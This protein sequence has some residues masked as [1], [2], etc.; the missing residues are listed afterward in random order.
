VAFQS[1]SIGS[2]DS[3]LM[4]N[5]DSTTAPSDPT[6]LVATGGSPRWF[7][8]IAAT[9][10]TMELDTMGSDLPTTFLGVYIPHGLFQYTF[11]L[12]TNDISSAPDGIHSQVYFPTI[13]NTTYLV[14]VDGLN[15]DQGTNIYLNWRMG[16]PPN[17]LGTP[18]TAVLTQGGSLPMLAAG[19]S[20]SVTS[21]S[22][23]WQCN[24]TNIPGATDPTLQ[25]YGYQSGSYCVVVS[26]LVG[27]ITNPVALVYAD[28]PLKLVKDLTFQPPEFRLL[29][30]A[31]QKTVLLLS[32]N[33]TAQVW[34]PLYTN[35]VPLL[36]INYLDSSSTNRSRSFYRL[37]SSP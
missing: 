20:N 37:K 31:P 22:Y 23:Q 9:N 11:T 1:V 13:S 6:N 19:Q 25:L 35:S 3:Q 33:L 4:N 10:A 18:S 21:P 24:G 17:T 32:T 27:M 7:M 8:L 12:V 29:G 30:S 36:P 15:G 34:M 5:F 16:V 28:I 14:E 2:I 26:N